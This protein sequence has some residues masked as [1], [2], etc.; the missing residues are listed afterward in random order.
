MKKAA[1]FILAS[2]LLLTA[3]GV[4]QTPVSTPAGP[5]V[6]VHWDALEPKPEYRAERW[7][8]GLRGS[9]YPRRN[10]GSSCPI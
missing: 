7:Y 5:N 10:T 4:E 6:E 2:A 8:S 1:I 3:C 9:S